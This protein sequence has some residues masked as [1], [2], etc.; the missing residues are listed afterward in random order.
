MSVTLKQVA[1]AAGVSVSVASRSLNGRA[2]EYRISETTEKSVKTTAAKLGFQPSQVA[3]S[4]RL[5][6][7]GL[8]GVVVPDLSNPFF[9]SIA[10]E[11]TLAAEQDGYSVIVVD[12]RETTANE[13]KLVGQLL[14]R[15]I[16]A[17][18]VCPVGQ[19]QDHLSA[20]HDSGLPVV[21]V[22]RGFPDSKLT[23]VTS[24]HRAGAQQATELLLDHGHRLIGILQGLPG[25]LPN[26]E[27]LAGLRAGLA[28]RN[29]DFDTTLL[30]GDNF[31]ERSGY[32]STHA[33]L[34]RHR[35]I[36]ALFA[37]STPN[38]LGALRATL[39]LGRRV[40]EDL[41]LVTFDDIPFADFMSVPLTTV[42]QDVTALGRTAADLI[43]QQLSGSKP[44]R[45]KNH[46]VQVHLINRNSI[47]EV[48]R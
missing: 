31:S 33:L 29:L 32:E 30:A 24:N 37:F 14:A 28:Q 34:R 15:Q 26:D 9:A 17:L 38:A 47:R 8:V 16:E 27:R 6:R 19:T 11:V 41:S 39:E 21:L 43:T 5:K 48:K 44:P 23:Q 20:I 12:T 40:P 18:V 42:A 10:R 7:S 45:L 36:T 13:E 46:C 35:G 4:L 22:D 2:R 3:R 25:T 1:D